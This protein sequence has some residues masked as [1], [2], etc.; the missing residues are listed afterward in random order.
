MKLFHKLPFFSLLLGVTLSLFSSCED[1]LSVVPKGQKIPV[2][3]NDFALMLKDEYA[4]QRV[5]ALQALILLNDRHVNNSSLNYYPLYKANYNWDESADRIELNKSDEQAYYV[6][7]GAISVFNLIIQ[8]APGATEATDDERKQVIAQAKVLRAMS[9]FNI[10]NY[11]SDTYEAATASQKGGVPLITSADVN[12]PYTQPTVQD[13]Y[14]FMLQDLEEAYSD[15]PQESET[16]LHPDKA[17]ADAFYARLYLQMGNY[18]EAL[19][20]ADRALAANSNLFDWTAFYETHKS[21]IENPE[22]FNSRL[23]SPMGFQYV[24]NYQFR[25]GS[26]TYQAA[27]SSIPLER[28]ELFEEGDARAAARWKRYTVGQESYYR[29]SITGFYNYGG[30]TTVEVYLIK[31]ECLARAGNLAE[32][33]DLVNKVRETR[34]LPGVYQPLTASSVGEAMQAVIRLK[35]NE[36][37]LTQVP[38][39]DAR[40]LNAEGKYPV[41]RSKVLDGTEIT[42]SPTSH[43][44]TMPFPQGA[45]ENAGNGSVN[46]NVEK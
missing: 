25:H 30:I 40:R 9:Y 2:T 1:Y 6:G 14:D 24:E 42:L 38:F 3:L 18:A 15:L 4:A 23:P 26:S 19:K 8:N 29:S 13:I 22:N 7:Y 21:V 12:A 37:I 28:W 46:Q 5:D 17:T 43:L 20:Y 10:V 45:V 11:Y 34:I 32:A 33:M 44:W 36:M 35:G 16:I 27:E 41:T 31:A 39:M